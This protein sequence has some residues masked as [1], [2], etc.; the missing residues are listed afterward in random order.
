MCEKRVA[1]TGLGVVTAAGIGIGET[2]RSLLEG[3]Q[4]VRAIERFDASGFDCRIGAA[5]ENFSARSFV[6]KSYRKSVK[7]MAGDIEIVVAAADLAVR[8]AGIVTRGIDPDNMTVQTRRLGC[9]IGAGLITA[10]LNELGVAMNSAVVDGKFDMRAWGS[11]GMAELTPLWLLKWLPNMLA[12]HVTIIHGAEGP[13]NNITCGAASGHLSIAEAANWI[14]S[15]AADVVIA[16][17][18]ETKLV[19]LGLVRQTLL[20]RLCTDRNDRPATACRPFDAEHR[21][22]VIGEGGGLLIL[23]DADRA[24]ARGAKTY[25]ELIGTGAACDP[26]GINV[27]SPAAAALAPAV[28]NALADADIAPEQVD[29]IVTH[30]TGV[31]GEDASEAAAWRG[32]L[33]D[34]AANVPAFCITGAV[35]SLFAGAGGVELAVGAMALAQQ[36]VPPTVNLDEPASGCELAFTRR[37]LDMEINYVVSGAFAIGGQAAACVLK[38]ARA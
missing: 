4:C 10:E 15:G 22:T 37:R 28:K 8:D 38:R 20:G 12:C 9:N 3:R 7:I 5:L 19:P 29:L 31:P 17:G 24:A 33:G 2:W 11:R 27:T 34:T 6:P 36:A 16:G 30:G 23:E 13:S 26:D 21:G 25:A 1:I 14:R 35:G 18:A 32:A